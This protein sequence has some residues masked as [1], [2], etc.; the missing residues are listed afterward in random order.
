M[1]EKK[2][3]LTKA[4]IGRFLEAARKTRNGIRDYCL[5]LMAFRHGLRVSEA[6]DI[7]MDELDLDGARL[8]VRRLK[9]SLSTSHPI[10]GDE[11]RA[12]KRWLRHRSAHGM[13]DS[14]YLFLSV[15]GTFCRQAINYLCQTI[16][17]RAG[18]GFKVTPHMLRHSCGFALADANTATRTIQD[19]LGHKNIA[20]TVRYTATNA[21][22]F[23]GL[24]R[25]A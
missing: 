2:R 23:D 20:H 16:G 9:N 1:S 12:I 18:L 17:K 5:M 13:A 4:E 6:V 7:R 10:E 14:P 25:K 11:L 24:W 22:R 15:R 3:F 8:Y 19:Y 21:G